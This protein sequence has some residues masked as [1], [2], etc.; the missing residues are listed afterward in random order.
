M[1]RSAQRAAQQS[2]SRAG[3][4]A[5]PPHHRTCG[6][7]YGGSTNKFKFVSEGVGEG[8]ASAV[9]IGDGGFHQRLENKL[10]AGGSHGAVAVRPGRD[11]EP[12]VSSGEEGFPRIEPREGSSLFFIVWSFP[13][14]LDVRDR[15]YDR[16]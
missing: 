14:A 3:F 12:V 15:Y 13:S 9:G 7:A 4:P 5:R 1:C 11:S 10:K 8:P 2:G 6:S 16:C